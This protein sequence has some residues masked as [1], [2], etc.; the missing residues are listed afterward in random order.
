MEW[1]W[2]VLVV[3]VVVIPVTLMWLAIIYE[4]FTRKDLKW[5]QRIAWLVFVLV[6]PLFGALIY[7]GYTWATADRRQPDSAGASSSFGRH[8]SS[9]PD[10]AADRLE[11][12]TADGAPGATQT[13]DEAQQVTASD[14]ELR[15][16]AP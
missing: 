7:L 13:I 16:G 9:V 1:F 12:V 4:L 6:L 2:H 15:N 14:R 3:C 10:A 8:A 11:A 5:W